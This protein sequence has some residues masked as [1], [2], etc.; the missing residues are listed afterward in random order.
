MG[1]PTPNTPPPYTL[2]TLR[3][4]WGAILPPHPPGGGGSALYNNHV[5][6]CS[7]GCPQ[8]PSRA[9]R[10]GRSS[11]ARSR[12]AGGSGEVKGEG[13]ARDIESVRSSAP[14]PVRLF[15]CQCS[16]RFTTLNAYL[17]SPR[18]SIYNKHGLLTPALMS[19]PPHLETIVPS[20]STTVANVTILDKSFYGQ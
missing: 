20:V 9:R 1:A 16:G 4:R 10:A 17:D 15:A 2:I 5:T 6:H 19:F 11:S 7:M 3:T 12:P 18:F 14:R 8:P 13:R